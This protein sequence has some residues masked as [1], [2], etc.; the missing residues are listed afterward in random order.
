[1]KIHHIRANSNS[2]F[3]PLMYFFLF[4]APITKSLS[5][6]KTE[7]SN[8]QY[9][10]QHRVFSRQWG[11]LNIRHFFDAFFCTFTFYTQQKTFWSHHYFGWTNEIELVPGDPAI[12]WSLQ[13]SRPRSKLR[14]MFRP[15]CTSVTAVMNDIVRLFVDTFLMHWHN[16]V[17]SFD[18]QYLSN[19]HLQIE[20]FIQISPHLSS[21]LHWFKYHISR[22]KWSNEQHSHE[23]RLAKMWIFF[24]NIKAQTKSV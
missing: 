22:D 16:V 4:T 15:R 24:K 20:F 11:V 18:N 5:W 19:Q 17:M 1:M 9:F 8:L 21:W 10:R 7:I 12:K 13:N 6:S 3:T 23:K 2:P 14:F